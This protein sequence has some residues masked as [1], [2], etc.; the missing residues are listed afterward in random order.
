MI[1]LRRFPDS[2]SLAG[3]AT[4]YFVS[5]VNQTLDTQNRCSVALSGGSTPK[6]MFQLLASNEFSSRLDWKKIPIFLVHERSLP[7]HHVQSKYRMTK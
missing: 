2:Q 1:D 4:E 6:A 5:T 3:G 7:A